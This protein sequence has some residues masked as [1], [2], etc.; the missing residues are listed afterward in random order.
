MISLEF[1][2]NYSQYKHSSTDVLTLFFFTS[3]F[4]SFFSHSLRNR[5]SNMCHIFSLLQLNTDRTS[6]R[7]K[8]QVIT[9]VIQ[10]FNEN[11][12]NFNKVNECEVLLRCQNQLSEDEN[13]AP[14]TVTFLVNNSP[15]TKYH[16]LICPRLN[17]NLSQIIT[18]ESIE[19]AIDLITGLD[20]RSYRI[21]YNSLGA[22]SSVNHLHMHL[23][24]V[25]EKMYV[26]DAVS[27]FEFHFFIQFF[28]QK[29]NNFNLLVNENV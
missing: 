5:C 3:S 18:K 13:S 24:D 16:S 19:F 1:I 4:A 12:F 7:R 14:E 9:S 22:F 17:D 20:D 27:L 25:P 6:L 15:I 2:L 23:I 26:E 11:A 10:P 21:G 8:P 29:N 28:S